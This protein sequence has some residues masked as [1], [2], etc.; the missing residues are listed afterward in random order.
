MSRIERVREI[1]TG[2]LSPEYLQKKHDAGW[3][4]VAVEWRREIKGEDPLPNQTT[5]DIPYGLRVA[6]DCCRLEVDQYENAALVLMMELLVQ[7]HP[8]SRVALALNE[9]GYVTRS[10]KPWSPVSVFN[11]LPRLI[12]VGPRLFSSSEWEVRRQKFAKA[13]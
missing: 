3:S 7:D 6:E 4:L 8:I 11:M 12:E 10:G 13:I 5:E 2:A 9:K 1:M